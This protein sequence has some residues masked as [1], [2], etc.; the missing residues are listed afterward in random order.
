[1]LNGGHAPKQIM[2]ETDLFLAEIAAFLVPLRM[3]GVCLTP[4]REHR[5]VPAPL[6]SQEPVTAASLGSVTPRAG[7]AGV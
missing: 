6:F 7:G 5:A 4:P 3:R 2:H 1:M